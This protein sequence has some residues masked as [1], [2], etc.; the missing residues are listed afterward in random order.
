MSGMRAFIYLKQ[1]P[2]SAGEWG[3]IACNVLDFCARCLTGF[4]VASMGCILA[5]SLWAWLK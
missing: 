4:A 1:R 3:D 5:L 2:R